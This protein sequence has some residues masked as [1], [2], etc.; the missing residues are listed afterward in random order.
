MLMS[1]PRLLSPTPVA[2]IALAILAFMAPCSRAHAERIDPDRTSHP[3]V[4][5]ELLADEPTPPIVEHPPYQFVSRWSKLRG[6]AAA[7]VRFGSFTINGDSSGTAIPFHLDLGVRRDRWAAFAS[8]DV[9][10]VTARVPALAPAGADTARTSELPSLGDGSGLAHRIG[11]A[12]RYTLTRF[13]E[14]DGGLDFWT[15]AG[16]GVEH[17]RWDAGGTLTRPDVSL[18]IGATFIYLGSSH[19][20]GITVGLRITIAPRNDASNAPPA[21]GGPCDT[22]TPPATLDRS[23]LFDIT[24]PFGT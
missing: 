5:D 23:F 20:A 15:E 18:G 24:L 2:A 12:G 4:E 22:A 8:Y 19:H 10:G 16:F 14:S 1:R 17:L 7:G 3:L 21:C 13:S 6:F 11:V 9:F